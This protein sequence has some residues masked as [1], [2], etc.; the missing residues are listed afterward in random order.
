[1]IRVAVL[2]G[3]PSGEHDISVMS[4]TR[5]MKNL[6]PQQ[7][8]VTPIKVTRDGVWVVGA[9]SSEL[10]VAESITAALPVLAQ[11]DV[12]IPVF[13]GR[14][15]E[16]G[17]VQALL[18]L[19]GVPYVGNGVAASAVGMDKQMTK[20]MMTSAGLTVADGV[21][22]D[23]PD[24]VLT[25]AD[26][27]RLGLPVFVKPAR[28]GSSLGVSRVDDWADLDQALATARESDTKILVEAAV[29]GREVEVGVLQRADGEVLCGP[30]LEIIKAEASVFDF[31]AKYQPVGGAVLSCPADIDPRATA[32]LQEQAELT[33]RTL[34]CSGLLRVDFF[35][36][37]SGVDGELQP[38]LNEVNTFPGI[39]PMSQ[40]PLIWETAGVALPELLA[41]LIETAR[42]TTRS[43]L[44][45]PVGQLTSGA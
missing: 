25:E 12:A 13:H 15:G 40:Y 21:V 8:E 19:I 45:P 32:L 30:P 43:T 10:G 9:D 2:Y 29:H 4:A 1:M 14:P 38:V 42:T 20:I 23:G 34:G 41:T 5:V 27:K 16:D 26:R 37:A 39:T 22:L 28:A 18:E 6:D 17:T 44:R 3:G 31:N 11:V 35:L 36:V 33:F 7:Y 24:A